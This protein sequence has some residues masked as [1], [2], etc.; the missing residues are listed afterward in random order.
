MGRD[1]MERT[2]S[3]NEIVTRLVI[4]GFFA[5]VVLS[6]KGADTPRPSITDA[7]QT[8]YAESQAA[9]ELATLKADAAQAKLDKALAF[10]RAQKAVSV[11]QAVCPLTLDQQTGKVQCAP[12]AK[13]ASV[14]PEK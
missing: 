12:E 3:R 4:V 10:Q 9:L 8:E 11:M 13:P 6:L 7:M 2:V 14:K 5:L 1:G